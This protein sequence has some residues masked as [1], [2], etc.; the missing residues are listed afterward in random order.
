MDT[1]SQTR[2]VVVIDG[3]RTP[4]CRSGTAFT[5]LGSYDL[6]RMAVAGLLHRTRIDPLLVDLLVMAVSYTHLTL[7]TTPY[8]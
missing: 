6:G 5:D 2:R 7:P 3:A 4:F 8:V 1:S